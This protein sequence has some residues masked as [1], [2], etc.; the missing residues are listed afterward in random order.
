MFLSNEQVGKYIRLL[1]YQHQ[2]GRL[3][4]EQ[5]LNVIGDWD[6]EIMSKFLYDDGFYYNKRLE[7]E[8][9]RRKAFL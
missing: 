6:N 7:T 5:V 8:S 4:K 9:E 3:T 2:K 1:C